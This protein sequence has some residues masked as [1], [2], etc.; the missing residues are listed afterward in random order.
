LNCSWQHLSEHFKHWC[1]SSQVQLFR[2]DNGRLTVNE[3][4]N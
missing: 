2:F 3:K 4:E 1:F